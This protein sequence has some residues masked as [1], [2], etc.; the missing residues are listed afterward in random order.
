[1]T[2][3]NK[4][5]YNKYIEK[6]RSWEKWEVPQVN[7][8]NGN[9][10]KTHAIAYFPLGRD[11]NAGKVEDKEVTSTKKIKKSF[12]KSVDKHKKICYNKYVR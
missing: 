6:Q 5:C 11:S 8:K 7:N 10:R 9:C 1:M 4:V 12:K 3:P 2:K